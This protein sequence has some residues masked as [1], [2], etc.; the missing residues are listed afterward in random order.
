MPQHEA[1]IQV[2][3]V[4]TPV[5]WEVRVFS[6]DVIDGV[7][8]YDRRE[9]DRIVAVCTSR[10]CAAGNECFISAMFSS[11]GRKEMAAAYFLFPIS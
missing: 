3:A 10:R 1:R 9:A 4:A 11:F 6:S 8:G 5:M 2:H 7:T